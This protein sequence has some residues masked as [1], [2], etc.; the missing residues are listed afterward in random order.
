MNNNRSRDNKTRPPLLRGWVVD[1]LLAILFLVPMEIGAAWPADNNSVNVLIL[2]GEMILLLLLTSIQFYR[3]E[4][5]RQ[6]QQEAADEGDNRDQKR[7]TNF[8][9]FLLFYPGLYVCFMLYFL[10]SGGP[11]DAATFYITATVAAVIYAVA[12]L[13]FVL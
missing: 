1:C 4:K 9:R 7:K 13:F 11:Y 8:Y 6:N 10:F 2:F 12:I 3:L 5:Q